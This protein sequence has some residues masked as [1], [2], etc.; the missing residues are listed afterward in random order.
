MYLERGGD[1]LSWVFFRGLIPEAPKVTVFEKK[2]RV[3][4]KQNNKTGQ[5]QL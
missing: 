4:K 2:K 5:L 1:F 3:K